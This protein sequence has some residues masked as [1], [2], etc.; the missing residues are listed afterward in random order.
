MTNWRVSSRN[1]NVPF[2]AELFPTVVS[3]HSLN[4]VG[5]NLI[6]EARRRSVPPHGQEP[7][8]SSMTSSPS[9]M[10]A[11]SEVIPAL[12]QL[13]GSFSWGFYS[14]PFS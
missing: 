9:A 8:G 7:G 11:N 5:V 10:I 3:T 2:V 1:N 6:R 12:D 13:N 14:A 4:L